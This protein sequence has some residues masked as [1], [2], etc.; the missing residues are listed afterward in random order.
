[1]NEKTTIELV[2]SVMIFRLDNAYDIKI[3]DNHGNW[4]N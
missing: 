3:V 2:N 1:M 4:T